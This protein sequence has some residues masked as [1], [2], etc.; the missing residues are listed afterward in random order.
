MATVG[1]LDLR[2]DDLSLIVIGNRILV[3]WPSACRFGND[4]RTGI[5]RQRP[6]RVHGSSRSRLLFHY[7]GCSRNFFAVRWRTVS[8]TANLSSTATSSTWW[9]I[10]QVGGSD[11]EE[12]QGRVSCHSSRH[13]HRRRPCVERGCE[14]RRR[15]E[16]RHRVPE[17]SWQVRVAL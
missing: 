5:G 4:K 6:P 13:L 11:C 9:P 10:Q 1:P 7:V 17:A 15:A 16:I 14:R 3:F 2:T 8:C 12:A